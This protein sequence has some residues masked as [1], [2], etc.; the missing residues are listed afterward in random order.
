M[1]C[2]IVTIKKSGKDTYVSIGV[3]V[4][5]VLEHLC[6]ECAIKSLNNTCLLFNLLWKKACYAFEEMLALFCS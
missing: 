4:G 5:Q 1:I 3:A 2:K 6:F